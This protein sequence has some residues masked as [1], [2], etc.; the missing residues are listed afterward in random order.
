[1]QA[2]TTSGP[3]ASALL[4][5]LQRRSV[6]S[7][8]EQLSAQCFLLSHALEYAGIE[9]DVLQVL[10]GRLADIR[11]QVDGLGPLLPPAEV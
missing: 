10:Q 1:M 2:I 8:V 3:E 6:R 5:H 9:P 7:D 4:L 11:Q